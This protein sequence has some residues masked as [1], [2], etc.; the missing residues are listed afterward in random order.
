MGTYNLLELIEKCLD[1]HRPVKSGMWALYVAD[2]KIRLC[3]WSLLGR[4]ARDCQAH[5]VGRQ[6]WAYVEDVEPNTG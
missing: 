5:F 6:L 3:E 2:G 4:A 1:E